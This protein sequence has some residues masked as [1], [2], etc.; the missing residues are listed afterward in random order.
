MSFLPAVDRAMVLL[1]RKGEDE[2]LY[3]AKKHF[4]PG[5]DESMKM[6]V[7]STIVN[8][9]VAERKAIL[10]NDAVVDDRFDGAHSIVLQG[11]RSAMAVPMVG[12]SGEVLGILHV[13]SLKKI[14]A[15]TERDLNVVQG[16]GSQAALSVEHSYMARRIEEDAANRGKL[17][18]FLSPNLVSR[19]L[20]GELNFEKGGE[21]RNVT[22]LFSDIRKF[23]N[24]SERHSPQQIVELLSA[25]FEKMAEI[26]FD[27]DGTLD[28]F[29]GD[30]LMALWGAPISSDK[31]VEN[32]VQAAIRMQG[33]MKEFNIEAE[34]ILGENI[35]IGV[36]IDTGQVVAGLMGSSRTMNYTVI[37]AHVNRSSRLCSA[38]AAG[39]VLLSEPVYERVK[40][41]VKCEAIAPLTL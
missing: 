38:A 20:Q 21:L 3:V 37:G 41:L 1:R 31:D 35:G 19:V 25:Y 32:A 8:R 14:G 36:G 17:Q 4:R 26:V 15:F 16:F 40:N 12:L 30:A 28:K 18:R 27:Y 34:G 7:S 10:S 23:T 39:D 9:V 2:G 29:I 24:M 22:I 5:V 6:S 33:A 13:D 11:I